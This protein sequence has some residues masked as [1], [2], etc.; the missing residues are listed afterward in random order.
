[1]SGPRFATY[2]FDL[3]GTVIDSTHLIMEA[4]RH[5][6][7]THLGAVPDEAR[8][9]AGF[10]RP[11]RPQL[12]NFARD[13][14]QAEQMVA[15]Y[16]DYTDQHHDR[17]L[18]PYP[19]IDDALAT[20]RRDGA[21]LA[22]VTSKTHGLARRGLA[23]CGLADRFDV[24]IG[25][26]DAA[27]H[28]PH[29]APVQAA[30]RRLSAG[31][32][33]AVFIGDSPYDIQ[34]GRAAG[35]RTAAVLWGAFGRERLDPEAPDYWLPIPQASPRSPRDDRPGRADSPGQQ[36]V[37]RLCL[38]LG[39]RL[40][41]R[42]QPAEILRLE[43][44]QAQ[45]V[46]RRN[47]ARA[48]AANQIAE[49]GRQ[50]RLMRRRQAADVHGWPDDDQLDRT[51]AAAVGRGHVAQQPVHAFQ[52]QNVAVE[53]VQKDRVEQLARDLQRGRVGGRV[54]LRRGSLLPRRPATA[55]STP[56][57]P[58]WPRGAAPASRGP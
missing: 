5:T 6:M 38:R 30:L 11:L 15:T 53:I 16:R 20:L 18:L 19:G 27:P 43:R 14:S 10:G 8:W 54:R 34:A 50:T 3:D 26:D 13:A 36:R 44:Q 17:L 1:M 24:V 9:R 49:G 35:V 41:D 29:P 32:G 21:R 42:D 51:Q 37:D 23:R 48:E 2:L 47:V 28:K 55:A 46:G 7:R 58:G 52:L 40:A 31:P 4:F 45:Q 22:I 12:A 25:M 57:V 39:I 33:N 56:R